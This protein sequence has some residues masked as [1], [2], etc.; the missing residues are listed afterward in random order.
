[1]GRKRKTAD[2]WI[3]PRVYRGKSA[4]EWHPKEGGAIRL[5]ALNSKKAT[6]WQR[7]EE[8]LAKY[9][10]GSLFK[11]L[12]QKYLNSPKFTTLA[13]DTQNSYTGNSKKV[14]PVFGKMN[15]YKITRRH[16]I[17][18]LNLRGQK[19]ITQANRE[20][21]FISLVYSWAMNNILFDL[22]INPCQGVERL[23]EKSRD[24]YIEDWEYD[25]IYQ[26]APNPVFRGIAEVIY[27]CAA[28]KTD[29]LAL[30]TDH[31]LEEG[32][33]IH[34]S[35]TGVKQIKAWTPRLRKAVKDALAYHN[36]KEVVTYSRFI[37]NNTR[38]TKY[39]NDGF[40]SVWY[41]FM[42]K[43]R[44]ATGHSL[45]FKLH[46]IKAKGISDF[47]G[48]KYDKQQF[49]GHK[50]LKMVDV[51]DRKTPTVTT[52]NKPIPVDK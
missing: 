25:L 8:E 20:V 24:R 39:T 37:F 12:V 40:N 33:L 15:P 43:L 51:Y 29:V 3:P 5:C 45:D 17:K 27:L 10:G 42:D 26:S 44:K 7:Y 49:S 50:E 36:S 4:Y 31:M 16:I 28:R 41:K 34:Q 38:G 18:Y 30:T 52:L 13:K 23:K 35:K 1:M 11:H 32:L 21:A 6:V 46:D 2:Q 48:N 14:L 19:S 22:P 47:E 9:E